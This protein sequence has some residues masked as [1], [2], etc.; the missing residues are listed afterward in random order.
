LPR[1]PYGGA[2]RRRRGARE[3]AYPQVRERARGPGNGRPRRPGG[4]PNARDELLGDVRGVSRLTILGDVA[5]RR[6]APQ[7]AATCPWNQQ[8]SDRRRNPPSSPDRGSGAF[9]LTPKGPESQRSA[10]V[11]NA[12]GTKSGAAHGPG[13]QDRHRG[14]L[15]AVPGVRFRQDRLG[16]TVTV[17]IRPTSGRIVV[18]IGPRRLGVS[19]LPR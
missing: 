6:S 2:G 13:R 9:R 16:M 19:I 15:M 3:R 17:G 18:A 11:R 10:A 4:A 12:G 8:R 1:A 5:T 14:T 7:R